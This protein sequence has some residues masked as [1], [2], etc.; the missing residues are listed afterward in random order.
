MSVYQSSAKR[1]VQGWQR[2]T[3]LASSME[4]AARLCVKGSGEDTDQELMVLVHMVE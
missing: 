4:E 1:G 3:E 2:N